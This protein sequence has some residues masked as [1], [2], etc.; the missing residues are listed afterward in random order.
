MLCLSGISHKLAH[1]NNIVSR[2]RMH[3]YNVNTPVVLELYQYYDI[4]CVV[5]SLC[6]PT[7]NFSLLH[8]MNSSYISCHM[9]KMIL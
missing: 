1:A 2:E 4:L 7:S 8:E 6:S 9:S 5:E 3:G